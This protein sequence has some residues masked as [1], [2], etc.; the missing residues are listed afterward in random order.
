MRLT[1]GFTVAEAAD[2]IEEL[3]DNDSLSLCD[4]VDIFITPPDNDV[5]T[6]EDSDPEDSDALSSCW[7]HNLVVFELTVHKM[8]NRFSLLFLIAFM[9]A[10]SIAAQFNYP[11]PQ[12][13]IRVLIEKVS[14]MSPGMQSDAADF[15]KEVINE[16]RGHGSPSEICDGFRKRFSEKH[17]DQVWHVIMYKAYSVQAI[18]SIE[19]KVDNDFYLL[20]GTKK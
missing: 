3:L 13:Q 2:Y 11:S 19:L 16:K 4:E 14:N 10:F 9:A 12:T 18:K 15:L 7:L 1:R 8:A 20:F 6:D 17:H 5:Q